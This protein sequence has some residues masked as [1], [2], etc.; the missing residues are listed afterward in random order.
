MYAHN[1]CFFRLL[2]KWE[3]AA[4]DL[5]LAC[6][7]DYDDQANEWLKEVSPNV[8]QPNNQT[9][10]SFRPCNK[11]VFLCYLPHIPSQFGARRYDLRSTLNLDL[12]IKKKDVD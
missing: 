7:I 10:L 4:K 6:K 5:R 8:R 9:H 1:S 12:P 11:C 2:G 3:E